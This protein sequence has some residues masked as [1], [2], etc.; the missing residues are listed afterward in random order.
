MEALPDHILK[1][2]ELDIECVIDDDHIIT[3]VNLII[4]GKGST[5]ITES[6]SYSDLSHSMDTSSLR[7]G[8]ITFTIQ[9]VDQAGNFGEASTEI[10]IYNTAMDTD[11]DGVA[12]WWEYTNNMDPFSFDSDT[13]PDG[14]GFTNLEEFLGDDRLWGEEDDSSDPRDFYS[15]PMI[16]TTEPPNVLFFVLLGASIFITILGL[17]GFIFTRRR[18]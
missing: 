6:L 10:H 1:G 13:D 16:E 12:D 18:L 17:G 15:R 11:G 4:Q 9:A 2:E 5:D 7:T 14:D 8:K 3:S